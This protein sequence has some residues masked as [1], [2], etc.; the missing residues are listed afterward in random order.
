M[1]QTKAYEMLDLHPLVNDLSM[2][3]NSD[4]QNYFELVFFFFLCKA[5]TEWKRSSVKRLRKKSSL[6]KWW[7]SKLLSAVK[8]RVFEDS[9]PC[10]VHKAVLVGMNCIHKQHYK[11]VNLC[12]ISKRV[13]KNNPFHPSTSVHY[14]VINSLDVVVNIFWCILVS[15]V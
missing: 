10:G 15:N 6:G 13:R 4:Q 1:L 7:T 12:G 11:K 5:G 9:Q 14:G 3:F 8:I 2:S